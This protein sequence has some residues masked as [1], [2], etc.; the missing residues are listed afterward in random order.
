MKTRMRKKFFSTIAVVLFLLTMLPLA[1]YAEVPEQINYQGYLT[2]LD[3]NPVPDEKVEMKFA[4]YDQLTV[5]TELWDEAQTVPVANGVYNVLLGQAIPLSPDLFRKYSELY[6]EVRIWNS[7]IADFET[8]KPRQPLTSTPF[9]M[10]A[11]DI[12]DVIERRIGLEF[13]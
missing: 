13:M 12:T 4:I 10:K 8:L 1:G 5:G 11:A 2:D 3:G 7:D 6:L 9:T